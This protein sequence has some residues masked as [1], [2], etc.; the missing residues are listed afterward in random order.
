MP[1]LTATESFLCHYPGHKPRKQA[2]FVGRLMVGTLK[3]IARRESVSEN[4]SLRGFLGRLGF[5]K[6]C[7][8]TVY[9][10]DMG[11]APKLQTAAWLTSDNVNRRAT[12]YTQVAEP[13]FWLERPAGHSFLGEKSERIIM[14]VGDPRGL[15]LR[16]WNEEDYW[17]ENSIGLL[18]DAFETVN[19]IRE[20]E[21]FQPVPNP[22]LARQGLSTLRSHA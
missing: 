12:L 1:L 16:M 18:A 13:K 20:A 14:E 5:A 7:S 8:E 22:E 17:P 21:G 3:Q 11:L 2:D 10:D 15:A 4:N 6:V 9:Y 19:L